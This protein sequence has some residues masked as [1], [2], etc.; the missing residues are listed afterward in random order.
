MKRYDQNEL[1]LLWLD[2][3][4]GLEYKHKFSLYQKLRG[5]TNLKGL[6]EQNKDYV[7]SQM[8]TNQY[9]CLVNA[10]NKAYLDNVLN[11]LERRQVVAVTLASKDYPKLLLQTDI[12]P[13]VLYAKGD[14]ELLNQNCFAI[15]GSRKSLPLSIKL[16]QNYAQELCSCGLTLVTGIAQG[17]DTAVLESALDCNEKSITVLA[18]GIDNV[19]PKNNVGI[20]ERIAERGLVISEYP[21]EVHPQKYFYPIR[22]RI[23]AGLA[24]GVLVVSGA[25]KSGTLYTANFAMEYGRDLFAIPYNSG[26]ES[27]AG[28]NDLIKRGAILTD[29][30]K[31]ILDFYGLEKPQNKTCQLDQL[32]KEI[33]AQLKIEQITVEKLA[34]KLNKKVFEISPKLSMLEIKGVVIKNGINTYTVCRDYLEE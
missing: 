34:T 25:L 27:G 29:T 16:A 18:G 11:G 5:Q 6:I 4:V 28:C 15:V 30:P 9:E 33:V 10:T 12:P 26:I 1:C 13:L 20:L 19:F 21:P 24:K 23:I 14:V 3:F 7:C 32:E 17:A 8:G 22:N 31:D 2:S